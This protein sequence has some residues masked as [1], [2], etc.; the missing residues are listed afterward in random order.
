M[1]SDQPFQRKISLPLRKTFPNIFKLV[2][3][4]FMLFFANLHFEWS[5]QKSK[6]F[7]ELPVASP[8]I[9]A[10]LRV[11]EAWLDS[12]LQSLNAFGRCPDNLIPGC[13]ANPAAGGASI[14][15]YKALFELQNTPFP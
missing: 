8:L 13:S 7:S 1:R 4:F 12:I 5:L 15:K 9:Y 2:N 3:S 10:S 11:T 6:N 14:E